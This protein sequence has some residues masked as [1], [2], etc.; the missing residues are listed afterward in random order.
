MVHNYSSYIPNTLLKYSL[1]KTCVAGYTFTQ[2]SQQDANEFI[3]S[4][5]T[6]ISDSVGS[7]LKIMHLHKCTDCKNVTCRTTNEGHW[8]FIPVEDSVPNISIQT[9]ID[10][11]L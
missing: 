10:N 11:V 3:S 9:L 1:L 4:V 7:Y 6:K 8:L 2:D 5:I